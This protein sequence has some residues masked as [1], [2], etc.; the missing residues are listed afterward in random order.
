M[1]FYVLNMTGIGKTTLANHICVKWARDGFL[2]EDFNIVV[3]IPLRTVQ[4]QSLEQ[5]IIEHIGKEGYQQLKDNL[6]E[7]CLIILE[8]L[9]E[10]TAEQRHHDPLLLGLINKQTLVEAKLLITSR[11]H[12]CQHLI[13]KTSTRIEVVG[14]SEEHL[15]NYI[16]NMFFKYNNDMQSAQKFLQQ[17]KENPSI[18]SLCYTPLSVDLIMQIFL[19][20]EGTLPS[21]STE[22]YQTFIV[23]C[24]QRHQERF[25][26]QPTSV[27]VMNGTESSL[28]QM[29]PNV[30]DEA[31]GVVR[32]L[33]KLSYHA[34]FEWS[35]DKEKEGQY[36]RKVLCKDPKIIFKEDDLLTAGITLPK[37]SDGFSLLKCATV[38]QL[39]KKYKVFGF[40]HLSVQEFLCALHIAVTLSKEEQSRI[41]QTHFVKL[42]NIMILLCGI[43]KLRIPG[44]LKFLLEQIKSTNNE[45]VVTA[46]KCLY[47]SKKKCPQEISP[48]TLNISGVVLCPYDLMS[49]SYLVY[50]YPITTLKMRECNLEN[51][52]LKLLAHWS[53]QKLLAHK[54]EARN[55]Q[56]EELDISVNN[57]TTAGLVHV[58]GIMK[59]ESNVVMM[60]MYSML[61]SNR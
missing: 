2:S 43:T 31:L 59:S 25:M 17:L 29:L 57:I 33:S 24:L 11:P 49:I 12:A 58:I 8:G 27:A 3:L 60:F 54:S 40:T 4:Q 52:E 45:S 37:D 23:M 36:H 32:S 21:T 48:L 7:K 18:K 55:A 53:E 44:S 15:K 35:T 13:Q 9:D 42:P 51:K 22:L 14:F 5:T 10:M 34:F 30:P 6:G 19:E 16:K 28:C 20:Q 38:H 56:L 47:E 46:A 50:H 1:Q 26:H 39:F 61:L 41:L